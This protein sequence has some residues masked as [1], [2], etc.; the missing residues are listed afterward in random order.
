MG[1]HPG[2]L[3]AVRFSAAIVIVDARVQHGKNMV[4]GANR[5]GFHLAGVEVARDVLPNANVADLRVV[6]DGEECPA[7]QEP[8][9]T[10]KALEVGHIF[11]QG[12]RFSDFEMGAY[13][14]GLGRLLAAVVEAHHDED[15][16]IWPPSLAPFDATVLTLGPEPE[17]AATAEQICA[18]LNRAGLEVLYDDRDERAGVKFKDADL[19]GIPRRIG[20]GRRGIE[21]VNRPERA[22][23]L[24]HLRQ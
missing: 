16:I 17:L 1:A 14:I 20:V 2:S 22:L 5:D 11:K 8:L 19:I 3:G 13:G 21:E 23:R 6:K 7:C 12:K 4:T 24:E 9:E 18:D 15:G 10:F